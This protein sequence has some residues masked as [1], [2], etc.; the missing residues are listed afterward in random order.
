MSTSTKVQ[1]RNNT[2][3]IENI[4]IKYKKHTLNIVSM[5]KGKNNFKK[6]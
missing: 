1:S 4:K 6:K 2:N 5:F 3:K